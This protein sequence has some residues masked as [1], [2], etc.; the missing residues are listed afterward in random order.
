MPVVRAARSSLKTCGPKARASAVPA[1]DPLLTRVP[2]WSGQIVPEPMFVHSDLTT[3]VQLADLVAYIV[4]WNVRV[5][6]MRAPSRT[7]MDDLG[8]AVRQLRYRAVRQRDNN[9]SFA[10]WSIAVI[11]DLRPF[12]ERLEELVMRFP[13]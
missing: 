7:E 12:G 13:A 10:I 3:G 9:P 1:I 11:P 5:G 8:A 6:N 2:P 4:A